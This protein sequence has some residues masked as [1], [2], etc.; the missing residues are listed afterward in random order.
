[1]AVSVDFTDILEELEGARFPPH[2]AVSSAIA[3]AIVSYPGD[4]DSVGHTDVSTVTNSLG[5][6]V[7][8]DPNSMVPW[9][10][11]LWAGYLAVTA[12]KEHVSER[13]VAPPPRCRNRVYSLYFPAC[14]FH[15]PGDPTVSAPGGESVRGSL[16]CMSRAL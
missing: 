12:Q 3:N 6:A 1:M 11:L 4:T 5:G 2:A 13:A 15:A 7:G 10:V 16:T 14:V 9:V 8:T